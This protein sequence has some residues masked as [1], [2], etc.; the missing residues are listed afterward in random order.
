MPPKGIEPAARAV[1][2]PT[3][4]TELN[5]VEL[6]IEEPNSPNTSRRSFAVISIEFYKLKCSRK[7]NLNIKLTIYFV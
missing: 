1:A 5:A 3:G 6:K 2:V 7:Q 4:E